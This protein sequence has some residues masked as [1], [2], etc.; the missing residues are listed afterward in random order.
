MRFFSGFFLLCFIMSFYSSFANSKLVTIEQDESEISELLLQAFELL[1]EDNKLAD[2]LTN[3]AI[4]KAKTVKNDSLLSFAYRRKGDISTSKSATDSATFWYLKSADIA[5]VNGY[6]YLLARAYISL[7]ILARQNRLIELSNEYNNKAEKLCI[8]YQLDNALG[9]VYQNVSA[10]LWYL[11]KYDDANIFFEKA[12]LI[13]RK[14]EEPFVYHIL[15]LEMANRYAIDNDVE[16]AIP[17]YDEVIN[18]VAANLY[19]YQAFRNKVFLLL[20]VGNL[21]EAKKVSNQFLKEV[22]DSKNKKN[23]LSALEV[24]LE[25]AIEE[26]SDYTTADIYDRIDSLKNVMNNE[27]MN[28][29]IAEMQ[30]K[31]DIKSK[32]LEL[33]LQQEELETQKLKTQGFVLAVV[34][35]LVLIVLGMFLAQ[36]RNRNNILLVEKERSEKEL[37]EVKNIQLKAAFDYIEMQ[38]QEMIDSLNYAKRIQDAILPSHA[39]IQKQ[40]ANHFLLY[41]PKAI[42]A[43]DFYWMHELNNKVFFAVGDCTGHGVPGALMS[44]ICVNALSKAVR[45]E[46]SISTNEILDKTRENVVQQVATKSDTIKDGMDIA[47]CCIDK[48]TLELT[49]SGAYNPVWICR[50]NNHITDFGNRTMVSKNHASS[51]QL[52]EVKGDKQAIGVVLNEEPFTSVTL[53]L[54]EGDQLYLFS[55]GLADQFGGPKGKKLKTQSLRELFLASYNL[56]MQEQYDVITQSFF[57]WKGEQEQIDD[58]CLWSI[59]I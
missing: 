58:I 48:T 12:K 27:K 16:H 13:L 11:K 6:H 10:N 36:Q 47:L 54:F 38:N 34:G 24:E 56:P 21:F 46:T 17:I 35:L 20:N 52:L 41:Q 50:Q 53:Q 42:V 31:H 28:D 57:E 49:F 51:L 5:L 3:D 40:F 25:I 23:L 22:S 4:R 15:L 1:Y 19:R 33:K 14:S 32:D 39:A 8:K 59:K 55:D 2:S 37:F 9:L 45:N 29:A 7:S 43:G 18:S 44:I 26:S 30:T